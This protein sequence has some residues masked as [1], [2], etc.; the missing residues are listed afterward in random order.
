MLEFLH[1]IVEWLN[2]NAGIV[3]F[4]A[5]LAAIV[6]P[7]CI[8]RRNRK[9]RLQEMQDELDAMNEY[10]EPMSSDDRNIYNKKRALEKSLKRK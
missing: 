5:L 2:A 3:S 4:F 7:W 9:N 1:H 10:R 6:V 8:Y